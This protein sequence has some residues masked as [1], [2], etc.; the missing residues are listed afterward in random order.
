[1]REPSTTA[2]LDAWEHGLGRPASERALALLAASD[3]AG[4]AEEHARL[5]L[6]E[7][8]ARLLALR[9]WAFGSR[10][11]GVAGCPAC[12]AELELS[13]DATELAL[14]SPASEEGGGAASELTLH[15]D[16]HEVGFRVPNS[17]DVR[18]AAFAGTVAGARRVLLQRCVTTSRRS[19][20]PVEPVALPSAVV[21]AIEEA[22]ADRDPQ[23]D[24]RFALAC[25]DCGHE[26]DAIFDVGE[27]L[28]GEVDQWARRVLVDVASLAS[29][30]GWTEAQ[31]LGLSPARRDA[32]LELAGR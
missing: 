8:D 28:W 27:F 2:L 24:V 10:L 19:G 6:G 31:V 5:P 11:D 12:G 25:P 9:Q 18:E 1:M 22:M 17:L 7:R 4:A 13:F 29:A 32:Y 14:T 23:A 26:W 20:S 30:Y 15:V 16:G 3:P 21:D